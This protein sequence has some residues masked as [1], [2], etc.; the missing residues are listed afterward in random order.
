MRTTLINPRGKDNDG[1]GYLANITPHANNG[2][3]A[4][5]AYVNPGLLPEL[6]PKPMGGSGWNQISNPPP[7]VLTNEEIAAGCILNPKMKDGIL[8]TKWTPFDLPKDTGVPQWV[9]DM[10]SKIPYCAGKTPDQCRDYLM[11]N[12]QSFAECKGKTLEQCSDYF[13]KVAQ[14]LIL[15]KAPCSCN[16]NHNHDHEDCSCDKATTAVG[17]AKEGFK[18]HKS[19]IVLLA[20]VL[21]VIVLIKFFK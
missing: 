19:I 10:S 7:R 20:G 8:C 5:L 12:W 2:S 17:K 1:E 18:K 21:L 14:G 6:A 16:E 4:A 15:P 9:R 11:N 13:E 3:N